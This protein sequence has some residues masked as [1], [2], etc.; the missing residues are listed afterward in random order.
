MWPRSRPSEFRI[1]Y[2]LAPLAL[3]AF[4]ASTDAAAPAPPGAALRF[5]RGDCEALAMP[6]GRGTNCRPELVNLV[7]ASGAVSFVFTGNDR[8]LLSF[9]GRV[10]GNQGDQARVRVEQVTIVAPRGGAVRTQPAKGSCLLTPFAVDRSR[11]DCTATGN[12][13]RYSGTFRTSDE[14]PRLVTLTGA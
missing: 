9:R 10:A 1:L 7:Y 2:R 14:R 3:L 4:A 8:R 11:L 5:M 6:G 12:G 13:G